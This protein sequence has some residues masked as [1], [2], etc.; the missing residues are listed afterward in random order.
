MVGYISPAVRTIQFAIVNLPHTMNN[1]QENF[2]TASFIYFV[3]YKIYSVEM[4]LLTGLYQCENLRTL[5]DEHIHILVTQLRA[6]SL[7][8]HRKY[9]R[10]GK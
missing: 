6:L 10:I 7:F 5:H 2:F 3:P 8:G 1:V 4:I 9:T